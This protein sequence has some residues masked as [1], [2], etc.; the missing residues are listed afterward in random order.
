MSGELEKS[1]FDLEKALS[2]DADCAEAYCGR[3]TVRFHLGNIEGAKK[4]LFKA[5]GLYEARGNI[6]Y[7]AFTRSLIMELF[8]DHEVYKDLFGVESRIVKSKK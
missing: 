7:C 1:L 8:R 6:I 5:F 4:D 2:L 3:G